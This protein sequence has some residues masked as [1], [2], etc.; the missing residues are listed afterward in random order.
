MGVPRKADWREE[1]RKRAWELKQHG[2]RQ[3]DIAYALGVNESTMSQWM[4]RGREGGEEALKAHHS[5]GASPR[6]TVDELAQIPELLAKGAPA[7]RFRGDVW[8]AKRVAKV[9]EKTFGVHYSRDPES[10]SDTSERSF[11]VAHGSVG[12]SNDIRTLKRRMIRTKRFPY[13]YDQDAPTLG[14]ECG[15]PGPGL[16]RISPGLCPFRA[17]S[18]RP[19]SA[20]RCT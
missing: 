1:R 19:C 8:T 7:Y 5:K 6:L 13:E 9:I 11:A 15:L 17:A 4:K 2:W 12:I 18:S 3:K 14:H 20:F 16:A 10:A